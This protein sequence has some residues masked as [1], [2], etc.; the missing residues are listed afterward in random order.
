MYANYGDNIHNV[1]YTNQE[2]ARNADYIG[3][4]CMLTIGALLC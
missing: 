4:L 1:G 3:A 2:G